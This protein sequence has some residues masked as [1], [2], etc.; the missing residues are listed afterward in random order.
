M[1]T[2]WR[3]RRRSLPRWARY[4]SIQARNSS[5]IKT[6]L[7]SRSGKGADAALIQALDG[8]DAKVAA[9]IIKALSRDASVLILDE[10]TAVLTPQESQALFKTMRQMAEEGRSVRDPS[11]VFCTM[12]HIVDT[13][14]GRGDETLMPGGT[15]FILATR[16]AAGNAGIQLFDIDDPRQ[17]IMH[18][19]SPELGIALP[20]LTLGFSRWQGTSISKAKWITI[21][22]LAWAVPAL[23]VLGVWIAYLKI[24]GEPTLKRW[25]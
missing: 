11:R 8:A 10:P 12:D 1:T 17:G 21:R 3:E 9:E 16:E 18:V 4:F 24:Y 13:F 25:M 23:V 15:A 6:R 14:P 5:A 22:V 20:G 7:E 19:V 2:V